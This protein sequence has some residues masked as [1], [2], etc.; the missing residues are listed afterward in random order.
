[1]VSFQMT[2]RW[3]DAEKGA[4]L[5]ART[6]PLKGCKVGTCLACSIAELPLWRSLRV[7]TPQSRPPNSSN[8]DAGNGPIGG[9]GRGHTTRKAE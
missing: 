8:P 6:P 2:G 4:P 7:Q 3:L 1:M 9:R 5:R